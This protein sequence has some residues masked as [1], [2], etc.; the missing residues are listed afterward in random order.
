MDVIAD[1]L[2]GELQSVPQAP[3]PA[4]KKLRYSHEAMVDLIIAQPDISQNQL[5]KVFGYTAGWISQILNSDAFQARLAARK[6]EIEDPVLRATVEERTKAIYLQSLAILEEKLSRPATS[7]PDNLVLKAMELGARGISLGGFGKEVVQPAA[8]APNRLEILVGNL[9]RVMEK[10]ERTIDGTA[11]RVTE[12]RLQ[13][14]SGG[15][16]ARGQEPQGDQPQEG[17]VRA[18]RGLPGAA[19][20]ADGGR[21]LNVND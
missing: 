4:A 10:R 13:D 5:A 15:E 18:D 19:E 6:I 8:P 11:E 17:T 1:K 21:R 20:T 12:V 14:A 16:E 2:L 9:D 3:P 7:V